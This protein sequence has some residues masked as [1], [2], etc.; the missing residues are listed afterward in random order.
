MGVFNQRPT[1]PP[2]QYYQHPPPQQYYQHP[3]PQQNPLQEA[4]CASISVYG[5]WP[6]FSRSPS[7]E[8]GKRWKTASI[9]P[10]SPQIARSAGICFFIFYL[11]ALAPVPEMGCAK[12]PFLNIHEPTT[13]TTSQQSY[14]LPPQTAMHGLC[15]SCRGAGV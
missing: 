11:L 2:Q 1:P 4:R 15:P 13:H 7:R 5:S 6:M 10:H 8:R 3:T 9:S 12:K 14:Q